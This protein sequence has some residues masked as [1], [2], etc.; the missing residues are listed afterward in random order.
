MPS[1]HKNT[2]TVAKK[3]NNNNNNIAMQKNLSFEVKGIPENYFIL[4]HSFKF[5]LFV[6]YNFFKKFGICTKISTLKIKKVQAYD[7]YARFYRRRSYRCK[8]KYTINL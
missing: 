6:K 5:F 2:K 7:T 1:G 3:K 4:Y 8:K